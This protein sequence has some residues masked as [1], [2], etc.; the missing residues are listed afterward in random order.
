VRHGQLHEV[1]DGAEVDVHHRVPVGERR[2]LDGAVTEGARGVDE[3][4][5]AA[6]C[7]DRLADGA[8]RVALVRHVGPDGERLAAAAPQLGDRLLQ[9]LRAPADEREPRAFFGETQRRRAPDA[10][11]RA[12]H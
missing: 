2:V 6:E 8:R 9:S 10:R 3:H 7:L 12:R 5:E 11:G 4:V 1:E